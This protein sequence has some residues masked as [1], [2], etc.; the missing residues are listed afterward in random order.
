MI[1]VR[2]EKIQTA[3]GHPRSHTSYCYYSHD[4]DTIM[5]TITVTY[6]AVIGILTLIVGILIAVVVI[7]Y[8]LL[9]NDYFYF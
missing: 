4:C 9:L 8:L 1:T 6:I 3:W 7:A 2:R 5:M